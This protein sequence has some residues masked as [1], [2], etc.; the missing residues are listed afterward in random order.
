MD[1]FRSNFSINNNADIRKWHH[2]GIIIDAD[3]NIVRVYINGSRYAQ[4]TMPILS[5]DNLINANVTV[6]A[7]VPEDSQSGLFKKKM[8]TDI[9][10]KLV[11]LFV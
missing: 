8:T 6:N 1:T 2:L 3:A 4:E 7:F 9:F 11:H 5:I 10:L